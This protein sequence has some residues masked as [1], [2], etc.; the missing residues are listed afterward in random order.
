MTITLLH[1]PDR[2]VALY[3]PAQACTC[4]RMTFVMVNTCGKTVCL[5]CQL[6]KEARG[7]D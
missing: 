3:A 5:D 2:T 6:E 7:H 1:Y 4:G